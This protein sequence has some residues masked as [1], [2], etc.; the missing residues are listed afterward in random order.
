MTNRQPVFNRFTAVLIFHKHTQ[1][2]LGCTERFGRKFENG[3]ILKQVSIFTFINSAKT[4][5]A[6]IF[7]SN[8]IQKKKKKTLRKNLKHIIYIHSL[9]PLISSLQ[10]TEKACLFNGNVVLLLL[11]HMRL[12][13]VFAMDH[14]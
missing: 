9:Y 10:T 5:A 1:I 14:I 6:N 12:I 4:A 13:S 8:K 2:P 3:C 7:I 11:S